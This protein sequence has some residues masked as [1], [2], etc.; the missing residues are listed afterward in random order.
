MAV[1]PQ[2]GTFV[3]P[4]DQVDIKETCELRGILEVGALQIACARDRKGL[5]AALRANVNAASAALGP[6]VEDYHPFDTAFHDLIIHGSGNDQLIEAYAR[7]AGRVRRLRFQFIRT[8]DKIQGSQRD[9][10]A[11]VEHLEAGR[12]EAALAELRHHVHMAY[13]GFLEALQPPAAD[14]A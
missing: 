5:C 14:M 1:R 4:F 12:D 13:R 2:R 9:H 3:V 8:L 7:I 10:L 11:I 6:D